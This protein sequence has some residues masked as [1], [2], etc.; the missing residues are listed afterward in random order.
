MTEEMNHGGTMKYS[1]PMFCF[2]KD[3]ENRIQLSNVAFSEYQKIW[4]KG[5]KLKLLTKIEIY[6]ATITSILLYNCETWATPR[7]VL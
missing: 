1:D 7:N 3:I 2:I 4:T 5:T 6:K